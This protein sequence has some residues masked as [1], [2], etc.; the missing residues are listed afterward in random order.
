MIEL[1]NV[2]MVYFSRDKRA[3]EALAALDLQVQDGEFLTLVGPSGCGKSTI[4]KLVAGLLMPSGGCVSIDGQPV[5]GPRGEMG[6]VF[7]TPVLLPWRTVR[8]N[9]LL[10]ISML[11]LRTD[12]YTSRANALLDQVGLGDFG[13][14]RPWELSGGMQQ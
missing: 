12:V 3:V 11:G 1:H 2:S 9:V 13:V 4:L 10:P 7:Q 8:E 14:A 6:F 5:R